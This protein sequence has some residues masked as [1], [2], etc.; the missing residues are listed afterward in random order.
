[1]IRLQQIGTVDREQDVA[2]L[3]IVPNVEVRLEDFSG[4]LG[5]HLDQQIFVEADGADGG[6]QKR[7]ITRRNRTD[8]ERGGLLLR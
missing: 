1:M 8:L 7:E 4:I 3:D 2:G 5:E 6:L